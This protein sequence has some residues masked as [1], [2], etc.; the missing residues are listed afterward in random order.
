MVTLQTSFPVILISICS[1]FFYFPDKIQE[2]SFELKNE[3]NINSL[4]S[5]PELTNDLAETHLGENVSSIMQ[6]SEQIQNGG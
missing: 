1:L 6:Q 5:I 4:N 3:E 2:K